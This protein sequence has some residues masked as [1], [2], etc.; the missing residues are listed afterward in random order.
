MVRRRLDTLKGFV[1]SQIPDFHMRRIEALRALKLD[2]VLKRKNPY[3]FKAKY[4]ITASALVESVLSAY[5]SSQEETIFGSL[6]EQ[7][8]IFTCKQSFGGRKSAAE[9]IDLEF[10]R[11]A[12][13]YIVTIKSGPNWGNS[14]QI[15]KM[16]DDFRKAR[17][18]LSTNAKRK[19]VIAING[20]CYG[21]E[22]Q[23]NKGDY[24]K[25]CGQQFWSLISGN[26]NLYIDLIEPIGSKA[27]ERN[28]DFSHEYGKVVNQ[29][30]KQFIETFC[31]ED[32]TIDWP[33]IVRHT[34]ASQ[35]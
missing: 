29:F 35:E 7:I 33:H 12:E 32:G 6:L 28:E 34:S 16:R 2:Q 11:D 5:L 13:L 18:I 26:K 25:L 14:R 24:L 15:A 9:G 23:E 1:E 27:K 4:V 31:T 20:C 17:R 19:A 22:R 21:Q 30:T 8:A 3:L 10:E